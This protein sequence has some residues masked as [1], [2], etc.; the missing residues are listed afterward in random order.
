MVV[1]ELE[2]YSPE[3]ILERVN[4][5]LLKENLEGRFITAICFRYFGNGNKIEIVCFWD[6]RQDIECRKI[7]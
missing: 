2:E 7:K 6:N 1:E 3:K 5:V 4:A